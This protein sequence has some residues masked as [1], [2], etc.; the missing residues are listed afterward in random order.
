M[1]YFKYSSGLVL[2][3]REDMVVTAIRPQVF[4]CNGTSGFLAHVRDSMYQPLA[5]E[6]GLAEGTGFSSPK[7]LDRSLDE[8]VALQAGAKYYIIMDVW[9][10][11]SIGIY[12]TGSRGEGVVGSATYWT[13]WA[14]SE[15]A[16]HLDRGAIAFELLTEPQSSATNAAAGP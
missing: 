13:W 6:A 16:D 15:S 7:F 2:I 10:T 5:A 14:N 12:T 4:F 11:K 3:P 1:T 8:P 9:T